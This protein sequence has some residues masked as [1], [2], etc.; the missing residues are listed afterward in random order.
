MEQVLIALGR[1]TRNLADPRIWFY[2]VAPMALSFMV[3]VALA[4]W[5]LAGL[6]DLLEQGPPLT[7]VSAWGLVWLAHGLAVMF[8]WI[9]VFSA[10]YVTATVIAG[11][12]VAPALLNVIAR[13]EYAELARL[14]HDRFFDSVGNSLWGLLVFIAG[15]VLTLPL[16]LI[17]GVALVAPLFWLSW[18]NR[19]IFSRDCLAVHATDDERRRIEEEHGGR[20]LTVGA[21]P[22]LMAHVPLVGLIAPSFAALV[23]VHYCLESLRRLR[24]GAVVSQ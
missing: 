22:A 12:W 23:F 6:I 15:W 1:G 2:L 19:R 14:G 9:L 8:G 13:R 5:Q 21:V 18:L 7:W 24:G 11:I 16:W 4:I 20:L 10:A 3:W 17:P